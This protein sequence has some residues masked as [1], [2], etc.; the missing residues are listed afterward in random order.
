PFSVLVL[1]YFFMVLVPAQTFSL[2]LHDALPISRRIGGHERADFA[3]L[4]YLAEHL[5]FDIQPFDHH[6]NNPIGRRNRR[7]VVIEITGGN[8]DRKST[9]LNSSHVKIS[10]AVFC[11]KKKNHTKYI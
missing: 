7:H 1:P 8:E 11:L 6:F 5:F 2:S 4:F 9:R 3:V 10:Y